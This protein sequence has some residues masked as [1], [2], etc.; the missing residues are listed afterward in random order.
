MGGQVG[1]PL[2]YVEYPR[3]GKQYLLKREP[4]QRTS[5]HEVGPGE[6]LFGRAK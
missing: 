2:D 3:L 1:L 6:H 5:F 4:G